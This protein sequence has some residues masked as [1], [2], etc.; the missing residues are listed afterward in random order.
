MPDSTMSQQM[1]LDD[2]IRSTLVDAGYPMYR[3]EFV[4]S[5]GTSEHASGR[6][7]V[8]RYFA[9]MKVLWRMVGG[10]YWRGKRWHN[11]VIRAAFIL[12]NMVV[13]FEGSINSP[14]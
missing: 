2:A 12:T 10:V 3:P 1:C 8:E 13:I 11:L 7:T 14:Y 5:N 4:V 6:S 9:R